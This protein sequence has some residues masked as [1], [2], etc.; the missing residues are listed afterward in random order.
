MTGCSELKRVSSL[1]ARERRPSRPR[2]TPSKWPLM[3]SEKLVI[4][5]TAEVEAWEREVR[6][7]TR[8]GTEI[9]ISL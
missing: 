6:V 2:E 4:S 3:K 8:R 9:R 7:R 1:G 5:Q